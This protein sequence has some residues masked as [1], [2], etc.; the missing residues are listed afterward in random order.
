MAI[1]MVLGVIAVV[2]LMVVHAMA[3]CEVIGR[4]SYTT[5]SRTHL[6]YQAES[7]ADHAYWM[8]LVDR[9]MFPNRN[10]GAEDAA[11]DSYDLEPWMADRREHRVFDT[12]CF[13]YINT[14][15]KTV[16]LDKLNTFKANVSSDDTEQLELINRF[17]DVLNDYT[18]SDSM[19]RFYGKEDGD[20]AE[21]GYG[22]LPRNAAIQF[23][24]EVFW[25]DGWRDVLKTEITLVPPKGK[26]LDTS[27]KT[28][29]FSASPYEIQTSLDLSDEDLEAVLEARDKWMSDGTLLSDS[30]DAGLYANIRMKFNFREVNV[31]EYTVSSATENG[32][33]RVVYDVVREA[34]FARSTIFADKEKQALSIWKRMAY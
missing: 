21:E 20:Y 4:E 6:R 9:R 15:E 27:A 33:L 16:R 34:N 29:F 25:L 5:A 28:S 24:E 32:E 7:A 31:A 13:V 19:A 11:R 17:L 14:V 23:A 10:L 2:L 8:H 18:D 1:V 30:L 12:N 26:T 3:I 22:A